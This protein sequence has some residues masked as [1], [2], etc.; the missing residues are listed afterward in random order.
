MY[1]R[2]SVQVNLW[3]NCCIQ[4]ESLIDRQP[5]RL[6]L[7]V[8]PHWICFALSK[9]LSPHGTL[10]ADRL[11]EADL[12]DFGGGQGEPEQF[13]SLIRNRSANALVQSGK[14]LNAQ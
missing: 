12:L 11:C 3:L 6:W 1:S 14:G 4:A 2:L 7:P 10:S 9:R 8:K 13:H 5:C